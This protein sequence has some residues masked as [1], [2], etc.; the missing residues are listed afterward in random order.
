MHTYYSS[1]A[2]TCHGNGAL[3]W[4]SG[5]GTGRRMCLTDYGCLGTERDGRERRAWV[6]WG[7]TPHPEKEDGWRRQRPCA[8]RDTLLCSRG[9]IT[10]KDEVNYVKTKYAGQRCRRPKH[11]GNKSNDPDSVKVTDRDSVTW[12]NPGGRSATKMLTCVAQHRRRRA[13]TTPA[14]H[15][16]L[17]LWHTIFS[18]LFLAESFGVKRRRKRG[19]GRRRWRRLFTLR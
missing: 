2:P 13:E 6:A 5:R 18:P 17:E 9:G 10:E 19:R 4:T 11:V 7:M 16:D 1:F 3:T 15:G 12:T 14:A 8:E